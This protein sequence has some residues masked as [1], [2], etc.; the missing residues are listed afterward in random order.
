MVYDKN[1]SNNSSLITSIK[2][3]NTKYL[4]T[5]DIEN[6]RIKDYVENNKESYDFIK[7]P[8]HGNYQKRLN[9]LLEVVNP[10]YAVITSSF[11]DDK[12]VDSLKELRIKSYNTK[13]GYIDVYS[14]GDR[15]SIEQ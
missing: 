14:D 5:G 11:D 1:E 12:T 6:Q 9:D 2:Y 3:K 4:F 7:I 8:Y 13:N 10:K 15:I